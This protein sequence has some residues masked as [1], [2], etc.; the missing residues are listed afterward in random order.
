MDKCCERGCNRA[1]E[2]NVIR[3]QVFKNVF[4][5]VK[6]RERG[7]SCER[8]GRI[9]RL[10]GLGQTRVKPTIFARNQVKGK[11]RSH[12]L[13]C[14]IFRLKSSQHQKKSHHVQAR[15]YPKC[16]ARGNCPVC[17]L[18]NPALVK[19]SSKTIIITVKTNQHTKTK[20]KFNFPPFFYFIY[21]SFLAVF[22]PRKYAAP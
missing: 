1:C 3:T 14:P 15:S 4:E 17:Q 10:W 20:V 5:K 16:E 13:R 11:K 6:T 19:G 9:K 18:L 22:L 21:T 2:T 7:R 12:V 8:Q